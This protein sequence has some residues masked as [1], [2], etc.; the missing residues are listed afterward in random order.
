M[1]KPK[2]KR[3]AQAPARAAAGPATAARPR[4]PRSPTSRAVALFAVTAFVSAALGFSLQPIVG[5]ALLPSFGG[6][7]AVW[8]TCLAFFQ[9]VL[10]AGYLYTHVS[11]RLPLRRQVALHVAV[12]LAALAV[13]P[14]RVGAATAVDGSPS[15][16]LLGLL[17]RSAGAPY[18]VV[19]TTAPLVQRW[20][21]R[22]TLPG[23]ADP[24]WL[25]IASNVG[26][27]AGL[28][29]YPLLVEPAL[30][31]S[32]QA[33]AW[34]WGYGLFALLSSGCGLLAIAKQRADAPDA[35]GD[36]QAGPAG[37]TWRQRGRWVLLALLPASLTVGASA[38]LSSRLAA[39]PLLWVVPLALY[40]ASF[41]IAYARVGPRAVALATRATPW[42][43]VLALGVVATEAHFPLWVAVGIAFGALF[44]ACVAMHGRLAAERPTP[45][46]LT[47]YYLVLALG[48]ALGGVVT[49]LIAPL[50]LRAV[51]ELPL[52]L[53]ISAA[54]VGWMS[55]DARDA[56]RTLL[57]AAAAAVA[58]LVLFATP[59][60]AVFERPALWLARARGDEKAAMVALVKLW[61]LA[62][63]ILAAARWTTRR[64]VERGVVLAAGLV[65]ALVGE[66]VDA[67]V[68]HR[69]RSFY[70]TLAVS[71]EGTKHVLMHG[72]VLHGSQD[73][74]AD[75]R[76]TP[77]SYYQPQSP[78]GRVFQDLEERSEHPPVAVIGLGVGTLAAYHA[79]GQELTFFE[80]DP[81]VVRV[82]KDPRLFTFLADAEAGGA[83]VK[84]VV[85]DGRLEL[86]KEADRRFG[87]I[88]VD[89]FSDAS[90]PTHLLTVQAMQLYAR[91][92][93]E[94]GV[95]AFH[96]SNG[97]LDLSKVVASSARAVELAAM[98]T[99]QPGQ[100]T[101][102]LVARSE[103][104]LRRVLHAGDPAK[105]YDRV[106]G[107]RTWTDDYSDILA[108]VDWS[109]NGD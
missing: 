18:F 41:V 104:R 31:L 88:V 72:S 74:A 16:A 86:A 44:A 50:V 91:K 19:T 51:I 54:V 33:T 96:V 5:R 17:L 92:L 68:I 66:S 102:L 70:G 69:D 64:G 42:V 1:A 29:G 2:K 63:A 35:G 57:A 32:D 8:S 106:E 14:V 65:A 28:L 39:I 12:L 11:S 45:A 89:A 36:A 26:S 82:A 73:L 58:G 81:A 62:L 59:A 23:A 85:G 108:V 109:G 97:Y 56:R 95:V 49:S 101:W 84:V 40:L 22:T 99:S 71:T 67:S 10:L 9:T 80:I 25:Y 4:A 37:T 7:A 94:D 3:R 90:V 38:W 34:G 48:G 27:A 78:I 61:T 76:G 93:G 87:V 53:A 13:I 52:A 6:A 20:L 24:Y 105:T 100:S 107:L 55:G 75:A 30:R 103:A 79:E 98:R 15:V 43:V 60:G 77:R 47:G 21:S 46:G 83:K